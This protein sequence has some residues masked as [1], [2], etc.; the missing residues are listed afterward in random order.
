MELMEY[1]QPYLSSLRVNALA[2]PVRPA[3]RLKPCSD[4]LCDASPL[5]SSPSGPSPCLPSGSGS[6]R[7]ETRWT[8]T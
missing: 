1:V 5:A 2:E 6:S 4:T 8:A 3:R 7:P